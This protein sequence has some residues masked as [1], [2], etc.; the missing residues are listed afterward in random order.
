LNSRLNPRAL[1]IRRAEDADWPD[2]WPI[3]RAVAKSADS[4]PY[5]P[6][7]SED[8][9]F[10]LWMSMPCATYIALIDG[11]VCGTYY[12]KPNSECLGA[13]VC[14]AGYMVSPGKRGRGIGRAMCEHS[15]R[16]A[17]E[18]GFRAMQFNLVV[19]TN[20]ASI[21]LWKSMGFDAIGKLPHAFR[22]GARGYVNAFVMYRRL[23]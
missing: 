8:E 22:H 10:R 5:A 14:N 1:E 15:L 18:L 23:L 17:V 6:D 12:I 9:A 3:V 7:I 16:E 19:E 20:I 11:A 2:I 21:R 13:H 4:F